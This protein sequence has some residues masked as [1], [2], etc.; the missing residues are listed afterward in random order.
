LKRIPIKAAKLIADEY[1]YD[2]VIIYARKVGADPDPHG[3][4]LTTYG[5]TKVHCQVAAEI[6]SRL[7]KLF[8]W[9]V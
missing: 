3:E 2:Q 5:V 1:G 7:K 8:G 6:G 4:H 9:Q